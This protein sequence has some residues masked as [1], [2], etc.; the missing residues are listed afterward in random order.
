MY[1]SILV[2]LDG[3]AFGEQALPWA[4]S[5][6]RR[7]S[8]SVKLA[9]VHV[10]YSLMYVDSMS[11]FAH[12]ADTTAVEQERSYLAALA[13]RVAATASVPLTSVFLEG[14]AIAEALEE[15]GKAAGVDLIVMTTH[16]RGP[17]SRFWLGSVADELVRRASV[18]ILMV[19]PQEPAPDLAG[20]PTFRHILIPLDGSELAERVLGPAGSLGLLMKSDF[21][22]LQVIGPITATA[23]DPLK[24]VTA[25]SDQPSVEQRR[26]EAEAYLGTV[27]KRLQALGLS[28][29]IK[30]VAGAQPAMAILD[31]AEAAKCDLIALETHGR[32]GLTR[33]LLGSVADK[34]LRGASI[35]VLVHRWPG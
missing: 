21:T 30:V 19:R 35:P 23:V 31:E 7:A 22:L 29:R 6:A 17:L 3:S 4:L 26:Q 33:L 15:H 14:P 20:E 5:I 11:A 13:Q 10:P 18:P 27:A 16:G 28:G 8:A 24:Y 2:P 12:A 32:R 9:L 25:A 1:R 34:V